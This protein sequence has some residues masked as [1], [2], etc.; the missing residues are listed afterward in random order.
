MPDEQAAT[1][2]PGAAAEERVSHTLM[3][4]QT[5]GD[6][7]EGI[8]ELRAG[9]IRVEERV[10]RVETRLEDVRKELDAK[11]EG[12]RKELDSKMN[13]LDGKIFGVVKWAVT[14]FIAVLVAAVGLATL[15]VTR[16]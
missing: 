12:V 1:H 13:G 5:L 2:E 8:G 16:H 15:I 14:T 7:R 6:I 11:I 9:M 10:A 3:L 4:F